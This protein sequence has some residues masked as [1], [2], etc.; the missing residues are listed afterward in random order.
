M[1]IGTKGGIH[2]GRKILIFMM[3]FAIA[4]GCIGCGMNNMKTD[5]NLNSSSNVME[6][7]ESEVA[8]DSNEELD[9]VKENPTPSTENNQEATLVEA[10]TDTILDEQQGLAYHSSIKKVGDHIFYS[11]NN[12]IYHVNQ[13]TQ[14]TDQLY[15]ATGDH[16]LQGF[17]LNQG[18]LYYIV[19]NW[20]GLTEETTLYYMNVDGSNQQM[21]MTIDHYIS[22]ISVYNDILFLQ[23]WDHLECYSIKEDGSIGEVI[24]DGYQKLLADMELDGLNYGAMSIGDSLNRYQEIWVYDNLDDIYCV[25][26][27]DGTYSS[28]KITAD[29]VVAIKRPYIIT[30]TYVDSHLQYKVTNID[31]LEIQTLLEGNYNYLD[32]DENGVY[33]STSD[34]QGNFTYEYVTWDGTTQTLF[35][36]EQVPGMLYDTMSG[37]SNFSVMDGVMYYQYAKNDKMYFMSR[38]VS[39]PSGYR[40][41]GEPFKDQYFASLGHIERDKQ[42][43]KESDTSEHT[44]LDVD[45]EQLIFDGTTEAIQK[46]NDF[47][48]EIKER[49][50]QS[51]ID[52][53]RQ[54]EEFIKQMDRLLGYSYSS[55]L[56][57]I[58]Y[59]NDRY[60]CIQ[61]SE[62]IY[63]GGAH[64][65]PVRLCYLMDLQT[66][67][68]LLL[69]DI[70]ENTKDEIRTIISEI[71]HEMYEAYPQ[72]YYS[73]APQ[74]VEDTAKEREDFYLTE[75]GIVIYYSPY[76]IAPYAAGFIDI[77]IPYSKLNLK[78]DFINN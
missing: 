71:F 59:I 33:F 39:N 38:E 77:L 14:I 66:G 53:A 18:L 26:P 12:S 61:K 27:V 4:V 20:M 31:T 32:V 69:N 65:M 75:D 11:T 28:I 29:S 37:V 60:V 25:N 46:M 22:D 40:T 21:L 5:T 13:V 58:T 6:D 41:I 57:D 17:C 68:R 74:Y 48:T 62:Y 8:E 56:E 51:E 73:D 49:A 44:L 2:M 3:L 72:L 70:V 76:E 45:Y 67:E 34:E 1:L 64:G 78:I 47:F 30:S 63:T 15:E 24:V 10:D 7:A 19:T 54:D 36:V 9:I 23:S 42:T 50:I 52:Y 16:Q 43:I 35:T 55:Y